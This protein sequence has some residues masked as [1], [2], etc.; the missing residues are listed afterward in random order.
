LDIRLTGPLGSDL[1][2]Q[3]AVVPGLEFRAPDRLLFPGD[4][5]RTVGV[6]VAENL[7]VDDRSCRE[8]VAVPDTG[9]VARFRVGRDGAVIDLEAIVPRVV[10][11]VVA[12]TGLGAGLAAQVL[13][14]DAA[15]VE[16]G[17]A[18]AVMV[19]TGRPGL[20]LTLQLASRAGV[21]QQRDA[22]E[23]QRDG[24][25]SFDVR[26]FQDAVRTSREPTLRLELLVGPR[27]VHVANIVARYVAHD[28]RVTSR[29]VDDF[30]EI[31]L[32]FDE[33]VQ[34]TSRVARL[35]SLD[36][37]WADAFE[38]RIPDADRGR[39]LI[40]AYGAVPP[41]P[42]LAELSVDDGWTRATRPSL[43]SP[44]VQPIFV[45][46][47]SD[48]R[49][50]VAGLDPSDPLQALEVVV[51]NGDVTDETLEA[52]D[53]GPVAPQALKA[54]VWK[55]GEIQPG[56]WLPHGV[57]SVRKA[58][59]DTCDDFL[60]AVAEAPER[61]VDDLCIRRVELLC[62]RR[63]DRHPDLTTAAGRRLSDDDF[64]LLWRVAPVLASAVD[65]ALEHEEP[66][67]AERLSQQLAAEEPPVQLTPAFRVDPQLLGRPRVLLKIIAEDILD[68]YPGPMLR[69]HTLEAAYL[70]FLMSAGTEL[71]GANGSVPSAWF[72]RHQSLMAPLRLVPGYRSALDE[73][74]PSP[75]V[76]AWA[77][78]PAVTLAAALHV[79]RSTRRWPEAI[80]ALDEALRFAPLLVEHDL[81]A[82]GLLIRRLREAKQ[83]C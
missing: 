23:T 13:R 79:R 36:R 58:L 70:E 1:F 39:T 51:A 76:L 62:L 8:D 53:F 55:V 74:L 26:P 77:G 72:A 24:R 28:I 2:E 22:V 83:P 37:P 71:D 11:G 59:L 33:P 67:A 20:R 73:R 5:G 50:R 69:R 57:N 44:N 75:G 12:D 49:A 29:T 6:C 45:G 4:V 82:A 16:D 56:G 61:G 63:L 78:L 40:R 68:A 41:G 46:H 81:I 27:S 19:R 65:L 9:D 34:L 52:L 31:A 48:W 64:R 18:R 10:W 15:E 38:S 80:R 7:K 3:I 25:W 47:R 35:W 32:E 60:R 43:T 42:Y 30:A 54:F 14:I 21:V 17:T 66:E